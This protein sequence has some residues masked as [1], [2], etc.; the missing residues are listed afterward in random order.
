MKIS[1]DD[2]N[3]TYSALNL[4]SMSRSLEELNSK[5]DAACGINSFTGQGATAIKS[6]LSEVHGNIIKGFTLALIELD[7]AYK[8][9]IGDFSQVDADSSARLQQ[10]YLET[11]F[12]HVNRFKSQMVSDHQ[13]VLQVI[14]QA[15]KATGINSTPDI[16]EVSDASFQTESFVNE[17]NEKMSFFNASHMGDTGTL[18]DLL[19]SLEKSI[20]LVSSGLSRTIPSYIP[21]T[22]VNTQEGQDL[23]MSLLKTLLDITGSGDQA[24]IAAALGIVDGYMSTLSGPLKETY[25][26]LKGT[27]PFCALGGDPVNLATGNYIHGHVDIKVNGRYPLIFRRFYNSIDSY[28][29]VLGRNWCHSFDIKMIFEQQGITILF[30]DGHQELYSR[31][32]KGNFIPPKGIYN[33]LRKVEDGS[34]VLSFPDKSAYHFNKNGRIECKNDHNGN[35]ITFSYKK[36]RLISV[37]SL[38]GAL[39]FE[40]TDGNISSVYDHTGRKIEFKYEGS[41]LIACIDTQGNRYEYHYDKALRLIEVVDPEGYK[42]LL[43]TYDKQDRAVKQSFANGSAMTFHYDE[44]DKTTEYIQQNG[45]RIIYERDDRFRTVAITYPNGKEQKIY[46]DNNQV[47]SSINKQGFISNFEYDEQGHITKMIDPL[48][49]K[50]LLSYRGNNLLEVSREGRLLSSYEYNSMGNMVSVKD[51][52]NRDIKIEYDK[53]GNPVKATN[54]AGDVTCMEYD[55]QGNMTA[56]IDA[57]GG[58]TRYGYDRQNQVISVIQPE[59]NTMGFAY[60]SQGNIAQVTNAE[61]NTRRYSYNK[62]GKTTEIIDWDGSITQYSYNE[63]GD[64]SQIKDSLGGITTYEY[65]EMSNVI[66]LINANGADIRLIYDENNHL[67]SAIDSEGY[68]SFFEYDSLGNI[69]R[70]EEPNGAQTCFQ[71]DALNRRI[72]TV[73]AK[74][75][76]TQYA[77][78][79]FNNPVMIR[80]PW[81]NAYHNEYDRVNQITSTTDPLGNT[82]KYTYNMTGLIESKTNEKGATSFFEYNALGKLTRFI[83]PN[84]ASE[85]FEYDKNGRVKTFTDAIGSVWSYEYD[86]MDRVI[87]VVDP[88]GNSRQ[89]RYDA[90]NRVISKTDESGQI[91]SYEYDGVGNL[92]KVKEPDGSYATYGYDLTNKLTSIEQWGIVDESSMTAQSKID[93]SKT[94]YAYDNR[95]L[96]ISETDALNQTNVYDYDASGRVIRKTDNDASTTSYEYDLVGQLTRIQY[97]DGKE[98]AFSYNPLRKIEEVKDWLGTTTF[99][100]DEIGRIT[101]VE[102]FDNKSIE[103]TWS[104]AGERTSIKYP[105]GSEVYYSYDPSGR[106]AK[107]SDGFNTAQYTYDALGHITN[108]ELQNGAKSS[109]SY[110]RIGLID[111]IVHTNKAGVISSMAFQY[112]EKGNKVETHNTRQMPNGILETTKNNYSYDPLGRLTSVVKDDEII[113]TYQYDGFGNRIA[114]ENLIDDCIENYEYDPLNRLVS[115]SH[116]NGQTSTY[117]YDSQ[118]NLSSIIKDDSPIKSFAFDA[119]NRMFKASTADGGI[120]KYTYDGLGRRVKSVWERVAQDSNES[121]GYTEQHYVL[122]ALKPYGN[123]LAT[124]G[125]EGMSHY[126]WGNELIATNT[127]GIPSSYHLT[128]D[129]RSTIAMMDADGKVI[130]H[131]GYDEFGLPQNDIKGDSIFSF[132]GYQLDPVTDLYF[133]QA[134]YYLPE[135]GRFASRD[136]IKGSIIDKSSLNDYSYCRNNPLSYIDPSGNDPYSLEDYMNLQDGYTDPI[137]IEINGNEVRIVA[138]VN[139]SGDLA[140]KIFPGTNKTYRELIIEG[141]ENRW[142]GNHTL[143]GYASHVTVTVE[144]LGDGNA[145]LVRAGQ[146][147]VPIITHD[148]LGISNM[149]RSRLW[150]FLWPKAWSKEDPGKF[151][152]YV[153]DSRTGSD[154]SL[155]QFES[156]AAHEFGHI[157]GVDDLYNKPQDIR[158]KYAPAS[159]PS[160]YNQAF[161]VQAS[162]IDLEK[163]LT[164]FSEDKWQTWK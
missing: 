141:I 111:K 64:V 109:Y 38:S 56:I 134:R 116:S 44:Q 48:G 41:L 61:G 129:M 100:V 21:G 160:I 135:L 150:G 62:N 11:I 47:I 2:L 34:Y 40:Y 74:G 142:S 54:P 9:S 75:M 137:H 152:I 45:S 20:E 60:D 133:A 83:D 149:T 4:D 164:A 69:I 147:V 130:S 151:D 81:G 132:T 102:D 88:Q 153:G 73:D 94:L 18:E 107:V 31:D 127:D 16:S 67:A 5:I 76:K 159:N 26:Y 50:T 122:D 148:S 78:D 77:Y 124:Y 143:F 8:K 19:Q 12:Q 126:L 105:D 24:R 154:Y 145:H 30:G 63:M 155:D 157:L 97:S 33:R 23:G 106:I 158:D 59:G 39:N 43:N 117:T 156:V 118:G 98:V 92:I 86:C 128:D 114:R 85:S 71:Y 17:T 15:R 32:N 99:S 10:D 93:K 22:F 3:N 136:A 27:P 66:K 120:A 52:L 29:G 7:T 146:K 144:D 161:G 138:F 1:L 28:K 113:R 42:I 95:G 68:Q 87:S 13:E 121:S 6:Y 79:A 115:S 163:I 37:E 162:D 91:I 110:N 57:L 119:A 53:L 84:G 89:L 140:D 101:K 14:N 139:I 82:T 46:N 112:D 104:E 51:S 72:Q 90:M 36:D 103:Y 55:S 65:D 70:V 58:V 35:K 49:Y 25:E 108:R 123:I 96:L 131:L 80:D 125:N